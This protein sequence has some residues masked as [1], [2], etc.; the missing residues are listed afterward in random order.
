MS[1]PGALEIRRKL[2]AG[3]AE[4]FEW[5]TDADRLRQWMSPVGTV[6]AEVDLRV[7]GALRI[8]MRHEGTVMNTSVSTSRSNRRGVWCSPG[9]RPSP[10]RTPALSRLN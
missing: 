9:H 6:E 4:V 10:A 8:V 2:P 1:G 7:G 5:W 3:A